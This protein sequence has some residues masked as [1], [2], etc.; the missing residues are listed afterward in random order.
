MNWVKNS[1]GGDT[2]VF[3]GA[4]VGWLIEELE[5]D[6]NWLTMVVEE[7]MRNS[8]G[9]LFQRCVAVFNITLLKNLRWAV[10]RGWERL[11]GICYWITITSTH[12]Q[13]AV[14]PLK[15]IGQNYLIAG[16][17][18]SAFISH[19]LCFWALQPLNICTES[20]TTTAVNISLI[21]LHWIRLY[22]IQYILHNPGFRLLHIDRSALYVNKSILFLMICLDS[23]KK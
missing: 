21:T 2:L 13:T 17:S 11:R 19:R 9:R 12:N 8:W 6:G 15:V 3:C 18:T 22:C 4:P 1:W 23:K 14:W 10:T 5:E 16:Y 7:P 20:D